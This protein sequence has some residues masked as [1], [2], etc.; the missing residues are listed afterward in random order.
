[1]FN[2]RIPSEI[3]WGERGRERHE[4]SNKQNGEKLLL[5]LT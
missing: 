5:L 3:R 4:I 1:M 2:K